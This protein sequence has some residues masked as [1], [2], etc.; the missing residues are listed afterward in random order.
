MGLVFS[1]ILVYLVIS[2]VMSLFWY[3]LIFGV[4]LLAGVGVYKLMAKPEHQ[5]LR[6]SPAGRELASA[7]KLLK[8][9]QRK[10]AKKT[11]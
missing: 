8:D 5:Q 7:Q 10:L 2:V 11:E 3:L 1:A 6:Q 9:Y 4:V